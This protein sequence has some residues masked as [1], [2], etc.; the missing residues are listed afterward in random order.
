MA[1]TEPL[2]LAF[3]TVSLI[4][5]LRLRDSNGVWLPLGGVLAY[6]S[7]VLAPGRLAV[8]ASVRESLFETAFQSETDRGDCCAFLRGDSSKVLS[9]LRCS[10]PR[11]LQALRIRGLALQELASG[12]STGP[13]PPGAPPLA[14]TMRELLLHADV[15]DE[16]IW[17][18]ERYRSTH[19]NASDAAEISPAAWKS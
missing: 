14:S 19:E 4:G 1:Y 12:A 13:G 11:N 16:M 17:T 2:L 3:L 9:A 7:T 10:R 8:I 18:E 5:L 15:P 6:F